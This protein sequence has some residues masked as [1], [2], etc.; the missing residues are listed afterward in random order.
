MV[1]DEVPPPVVDLDLARLDDLL[2][3]LDEVFATL[4]DT[5]D[6]GEEK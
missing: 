1:S 4:Q 2:K 3:D 5:M 6:E